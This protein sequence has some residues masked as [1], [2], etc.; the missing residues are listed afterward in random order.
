SKHIGDEQ[1]LLALA[2]EIGLDQEEAAATLKSDQFTDS[3]REDGQEASRFGANGV[4]FYV[5][6]RKYAVSGAQPSD[7]FLQA[8]EKVWEE[9]NPAVNLRSLSPESGDACSDGACGPNK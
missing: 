6:N 2:K 3:V 8:L 1:T 9:E 5:I 4:P 7:V